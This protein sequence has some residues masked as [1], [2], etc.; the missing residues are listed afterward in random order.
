MGVISTLLSGAIDV[1]KEHA[2]KVIDKAYK[3]GIMHKEGQALKNYMQRVADAWVNSDSPDSV[4][5]ESSKGSKVSLI[6]IMKSEAPKLGK[7]MLL[8]LIPFGPEVK[9]Q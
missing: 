5:A 3:S 9:E 2:P 8:G 1:V 6:D 4:K 7:E